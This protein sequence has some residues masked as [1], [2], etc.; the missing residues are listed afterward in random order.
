ME[1]KLQGTW[2]PAGR[3]S[4]ERPLLGPRSSAVPMLS[5][6]QG[7]HCLHAESSVLKP[8]VVTVVRPGGHPL[9]KITLL[10]NRRSVQ[11]FEQ[12]LADVSEALGF[13]RWKSDRVRKLFNLK[14]REIHSVSDFFREGD[15]FIATGK[16][17]LTLK[18]IQAA[19]EE[20]YPA[21]AR[22][23]TLTQHSRLPSPRLR[24]RLYSKTLKGGHHAGET[25]AAQSCSEAAGSQAAIRHQGKTP[26]EPVLENRAKA[27]KTWVRGKREPDPGGQ[28][29]REAPVERRASGEK[30]LGV[31][32]EK[33]SGEIIR[34]DKCRRERELRQSLRR[35]RLSLGTSQLDLGRCQRYD[36]EKLVRTRSCRRSPEAEA[37]CPGGEEGPKGDGHRSSPRNPA[38]EARPS[39]SGDRKEGREPEGQEGQPQG[40]AKAQDVAEAQPGAEE[41]PRDGRRD[42]RSRPGGWGPRE[43]QANS[44][45][46][47]RARGEEQEAEKE[48]KPCTSGGRRTLPR[49][50]QP[51]RVEKEPNL[52]PEESRAER[53][54]GRKRR[55]A[56]I[57]AAD[58]GKLYE[59]GRVIGDGNFAVVKECRHRDTGQAYAMKIIDKSKLKGKEDMMDSEILIIQS[60][61][62]PN[63]VKLHEVYETDAEIYL[64]MEYVQGGDL[65][66][67]IIEH[68]KFPEHDA[69]LMLMD[70]CQALVH[71]H[72]KNIVHRD[73]KPE[74]LLVQ[75]NEDK[76]TT[77]K[78]ADFGLAKHVVRP[79][80]T[81]CG[82]P[83]YVAPEI[84]SEKGYGLE[85]DMWAAGVI[86][87]IL[88][89]GFPPFRSLERDQDELF[90]IIQLGH[91]EFLA[92]YWDN[93]SEGAKDLV[94]RLL[95]VDPKKRYTAH[96]VL[97][98]P[99]IETAGK[100]S[101]ANPRKEAS[102]GSK[103]HLR[104]QHAQSA[105]QASWSP[106]PV[107][108]Q[109]P[110]L[111]KDK[112]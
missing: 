73:L 105:E 35:D 84:L 57:L 37:P 29:P 106:P 69:A 70:L 109:P 3:G 36:V 58:V 18:N 87:Y 17:P 80:F 108:V 107:P 77:L 56:G 78:L 110:A 83:T 44:E 26:V 53:P 112:G 38:Q 11:T 52:R 100:T 30:H 103:G 48:R 111:L 50:D 61:S 14:G 39:Q 23:L 51:A 42:A 43:Q 6:P 91:F 5:P 98:H 27:Q 85:V 21:K 66:D 75:R 59:T 22:A 65:F 45:K 15:A 101:T 94:S 62:H 25:E 67:A 72:D 96:Q 20:L 13:P 19:M 88:L 86:L 63:I 89:C 92:P 32:I 90:D 9:R 10:L 81:V 104:S 76:S 82:T 55:P 33:T 99:W 24:S 95:V 47:P 2:L 49:G 34:C 71:M 93:I 8:R 7:R 4:L 60:L 16:E 46:P 97:K 54:G 28:P 1:R 102:P 31:E 64:I 74:N 79:V 41:G 12:L 40:A 68:V